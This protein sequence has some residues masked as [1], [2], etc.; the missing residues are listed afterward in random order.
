[1][2]QRSFLL[3][4]ALTMAVACPSGD[5]PDSV[6][7]PD[8]S[9]PDDT[10]AQEDADSDPPVDGGSDGGN[11][12]GDD[13]GT[14]SGT[15]G[16]TDSGT[17]SGTNPQP[18]PL[19]PRPTPGLMS[20]P[21]PSP[22]CSTDGAQ[23]YVANAPTNG[24]GSQAS[25]FNTIQEALNLAMPGDTVWVMP[26]EYDVTT[27]THTARDGTAD[28]R[29]CLRAFDP[30]DRPV[31][32]RA[33]EYGGE[34]FLIKHQYFVLDGFV[35]DGNYASDDFAARYENSD[36]PGGPRE[37][38]FRSMIAVTHWGTC[39]GSPESPSSSEV[40]YDYN[41]DHAIIRNVS[42]GHNQVDCLHIAADDVLVENSE[43]HHC[44]RGTFDTQ[45]D[46]H[47]VAVTHARDVRLNHVDIH[48]CS[49]DSLQ[50]DADIYNKC[51]TQQ[52]DNL[53][54]ENTRLWTSALQGQHAGWNDG[55]NPGENGI[56]TKT[57]ETPEHRVLRP[58]VSL[59]NVE[60][61]GWDNSGYISTRAVFNVKYRVDWT[62]DGINIH[63]NQYA[64]RIRGGYNNEPQGSAT[65]QMANV[66][67]YDNDNV[68]R[69]ER[70]VEDLHIYNSTFANNTNLFQHADCPDDLCYEADTYEMFNSLFLG[71]LAVEGEGSTSNAGVTAD[72]FVDAAN[73]DYQ[74]AAGCSA[75]NAGID[76][77]EVVED[78]AGNPRPAGAYDI[79]AYEHQ[80]D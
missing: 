35:L 6:N 49:G 23:Y 25:P 63:G 8:A 12:A 71:D 14:D 18:E 5:S 39:N 38:A 79:G 55:E 27:R 80:A 68:A 1:M 56:D 26:G 75:I 42:M 11:D 15:D 33:G 77:A 36:T 31:L 76:V 24:D 22:E 44:L 10:G 74:L 58:R 54:I 67:A 51:G 60:A 43:I 72:C 30:D 7:T 9:V 29:I 45:V 19:G 2:Q 52:W 4:L 17:D 57:F 28:E 62:M 46:S 41:G 53:R 65:L 3:V 40:Y 20:T 37:R 73:H 32:T 61:F 34:F 21:A 78:I 47:C 16:G 64:F 70:Y 66:L 13:A 50:V 59:V 69:I 48:H